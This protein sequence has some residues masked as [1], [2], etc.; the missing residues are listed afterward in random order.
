MDHKLKEWNTLVATIREGTASSNGRLDPSWNP[1]AQDVRT[2][3][4]PTPKAPAAPNRVLPN[5]LTAHK[6]N[7]ASSPSRVRQI[8]T[9]TVARAPTPPPPVA[10]HHAPVV[11][12]PPERRL[13]PDNHVGSHDPRCGACS[14]YDSV[15]V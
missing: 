10:G 4:P 15:D 12:T 5:E 3:A 11:H 7:R 2:P 13:P 6:G 1:D 9:V 14:C 8:N